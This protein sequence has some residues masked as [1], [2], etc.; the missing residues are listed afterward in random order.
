MCTK[1]AYARA[2]WMVSNVLTTT[3]L[4]LF[5]RHYSGEPVSEEIFTHSHMPS[6]GFYGAGEGNRGRCTDNP[7]G[8]HPTRTIGAPTS[9][10]HTIFMPDAIPVATLLIYPGLGQ[11]PS[12]LGWTPSGLVKLTPKKTQNYKSQKMKPK[13]TCKFKNCSYACVQNCHTQ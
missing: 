5:V 10:I 7:P 9:I 8:S 13:P 11:A 6:S 2:L 3:I 4:R 12:M 1:S